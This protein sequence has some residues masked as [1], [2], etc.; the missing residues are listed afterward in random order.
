MKDPNDETG[1]GALGFLSSLRIEFV[2]PLSCATTA[3]EGVLQTITQLGLLYGK[4]VIAYQY[5]ETE[6]SV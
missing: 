2:R 5:S 4:E 6:R 1:A 3:I